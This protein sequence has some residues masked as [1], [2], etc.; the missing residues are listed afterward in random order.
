MGFNSAFKGLIALVV[1]LYVSQF[2]AKVVFI[3]L[4]SFQTLETCKAAIKI[5][6]LS[7]IFSGKESN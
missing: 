2:I 6:S 3:G 7:Y 1:L 5:S 4:Q